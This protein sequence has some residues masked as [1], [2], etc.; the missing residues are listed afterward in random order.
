VAR[1]LTR[2]NPARNI[3]RSGPFPDIG[4]LLRDFALAPV[5]RDLEQAPRMK[6]DIEETDQAYIVRADVPGADREN[7]TVTVDGNTVSIRANV[8]QER[9][10]PNGNMIA[11]ERVYGEE[12][13]TFSLPQDIDESKA[14]AAVENGVLILTLPKK[15]GAGATKLDIQQKPSGEAG[16]KQAAGSAQGQA[17][18]GSAQGQAAS[19]SAQGQS[20]SASGQ[21]A[22]SSAAQSKSAGAADEGKKS[23]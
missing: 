10:E 9:T 14:Q 6:V 16:Q 8:E 17:A 2:S 19:G 22:A 1:N 23:S 7:I 5:L 13:R 21:G 18:S 4:N 3:V 20:A 11:V 15:T 12:F